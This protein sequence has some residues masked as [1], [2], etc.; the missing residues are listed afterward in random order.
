MQH[1]NVEIKSRCSDL[2]PARDFLKSQGA[3][4]RGVDHQV[5]TYFHVSSGRLKLRQGEIENSLIYYNRPDTSGPKISDVTL[6][7]VSEGKILRELLEKSLGVLAVVDKKREI[8]FLGNVKFH[9]DNV[10]GL[11]LF[12]EIEAIDRE[13]TIGRERLLEQCKY[14]IQRMQISEEDMLSSSYSDMLINLR[15]EA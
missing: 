15:T 2:R 6:C 5:D 13:G 3:D 11:G 4:F 9:L 10:K 14:F 12:V 8:F 1:I 7:P